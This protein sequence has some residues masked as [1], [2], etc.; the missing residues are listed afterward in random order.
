MKTDWSSDVL[1]LTQM[2]QG[3]ACNIMDEISQI[4]IHQMMHYLA[5]IIADTTD[6]LLQIAKVVHAVL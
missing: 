3:L 1:K 6:F 5:D 4:T 2:V